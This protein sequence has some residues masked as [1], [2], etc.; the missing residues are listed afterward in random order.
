LQDDL[1]LSL[2]RQ[3]RE[4]VVEN[5]LLERRIIDLQVEQLD[6]QAAETRRQAWTTRL[7]LAR[8][9]SLMIKSDI[10]VRL[11]QILGIDACSFW[12]EGL[13]EKF[14]GRVRPIWT[15]ALTQRAKFRKVL[16]ESYSRLCLWMNRYIGH[17]GNLDNE[18]SAV[19]RNIGSF[20][21]NFDLLSIL[22]FL[23]GLDTSAI[24]RKNIMGD[25]FTP[26]EMAELDK[27]LYIG[28]VTLQKLNVPPPLHLPEADSIRGEL[29]NLAEEIFV[30]HQ[31]E[32]KKVLLLF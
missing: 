31:E 9:S 29:S 23:R 26:K 5:Y 17:Y 25:N 3:V 28:P 8:L 18:C 19:N 12:V 22:S 32:A 13:D 6:M 16:L 4:E 1:V 14:K 7:R 27:N 24:E 21:K 30:L 10:Q 11:L 20:N 2:T 15:R